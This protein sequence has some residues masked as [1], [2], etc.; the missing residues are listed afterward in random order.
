MPSMIEHFYIF[1]YN[2]WQFLDNLICSIER[3]FLS[4]NITIVDDCSDDTETL[5]YLE[6]TTHRVVVPHAKQEKTSKYGNLYKN[7]NWMMNDAKNNC[8]E[9][10]IAASEDMQVVRPF[11]PRDAANLQAYFENV[12][13]SFQC[14]SGFLEKANLVN[15]DPI[16]NYLK[17]VD[18]CDFFIA[19]GNKY[20]YPRLYF[21]DF[22]II[23][24]DR[25]FELFEKY[26]KSEEDCMLK[27]YNRG[28]VLGH[29]TCP[30]SA[31]LPFNTY[32]RIQE[33]QH[34]TYLINK[35]AQTG[36]YP[37]NDMNQ[38]QMQS[39]FDRSGC[40]LAFAE[41]WLDCPGVP[42]KN[43]WSFW[44]GLFNLEA[45]DDERKQLSHDLI[46][47]QQSSLADET[48][49]SVMIDLCEKFILRRNS[50][51]HTSNCKDTLYSYH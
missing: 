15:P 23:R 44:G 11:T 40:E 19:D 16:T 39:L 37:Y 4:H 18:N 9:C 25:F 45:Y 31:L 2:R 26:E 24:V 8:F 21:S 28:L 30:F 35:I 17:K 12:A 20:K 7:K 33:N 47:V 5:D 10:I 22:G 1:S 50:H 13:N 43:L 42:N 3:N 48:K 14:I 46:K 49:H 32:H 29:C 41:D 34:L 6:R 51:G 38:T 36:F 27:A